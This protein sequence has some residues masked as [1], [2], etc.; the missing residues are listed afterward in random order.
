MCIHFGAVKV[1]HSNSSDKRES[2]LTQSSFEQKLAQIDLRYIGGWDATYSEQVDAS[3]K[4]Q[5][6]VHEYINEV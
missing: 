3:I 1:V 5:F 4:W 6:W 2:S